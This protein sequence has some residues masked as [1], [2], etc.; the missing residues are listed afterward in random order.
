MGVSGSAKLAGVMGSPVSHS[1]SPRLHAYWLNFYAIDG[2]Y[3]PMNVRSED[4]E[5]ALKALPKIGFQGVNLTAPHK[6]TGLRFM[7]SI[8][9]RSARIGA[10]NTVTI[11]QEGVLYGDNTD[12]FGF[13]ENL[14]NQSQFVL[15][16]GASVAVLGAG[17]AARAIIAGLLDAGAAEIRLVNRNAERAEAIARDFMSD[18]IQQILTFPWSQAHLAFQDAEIIVNTT[19]MG[20]AGQG[21]L[22]IDF[23]Q[24]SSTAL[25]TDVV[26]NPLRTKFLNQARLNGNPTVDGL[27]MLLHQARPGFEAW[28]G[29]RPQVTDGLRK[30]VE[31]GLGT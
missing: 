18:S 16:K 23:K 28:F 20:T 2:L 6:E 12:G 1:L 8:S 19:P 10:V 30:H 15:I 26:Y 14:Q 22:S 25:V 13:I 4:L 31:A 5:A 9:D 17:G 7:D 3:L 21:S 11:D 27:G 24:V 29:E